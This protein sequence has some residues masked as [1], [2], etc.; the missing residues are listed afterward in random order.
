[1]GHGAELVLLLVRKRTD[2]VAWLKSDV[3]TTWPTLPPVCR[4]HADSPRMMVPP[5]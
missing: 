5:R 1:M 4:A 3:A 2:S